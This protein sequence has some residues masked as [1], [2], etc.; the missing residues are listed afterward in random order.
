MESLLRGGL[1][2]FT[3]TTE[4]TMAAEGDVPL[5]RLYGVLFEGDEA[6]RSSLQVG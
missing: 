5:A 2:E 4:S 1:T 3:K 6:L